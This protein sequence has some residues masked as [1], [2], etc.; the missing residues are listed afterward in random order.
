M[1]K[2]KETFR[3]FIG[4]Y[5]DDMSSFENYESIKCEL[6]NMWKQKIKWVSQ[7]NLHMTWKFLGNITQSRIDRTIDNLAITLKEFK[8]MQ[9]NFNIITIWPKANSPRQIVWLG[10]D[11][12]NNI[13]DNFRLFDKSLSRVG[14]AREKRSFKPH[15]TLGRFKLKDKLNDPLEPAPENLIAPIVMN[16]NK[17]SIIKSDLLPGGPVYTIIKELEI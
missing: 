6:E 11:L 4:S 8:P 7:E 13:G 15:I 5:L 16:I 14:F 3:I 12:R 2:Q 10:S 9:I 1:I 17:L